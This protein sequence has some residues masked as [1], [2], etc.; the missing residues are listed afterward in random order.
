MS[1]LHVRRACD[2]VH[3]GLPTPPFRFRP[4][5]LSAM[6]GAHSSWSGYLLV[7]TGSG[8]IPI[9]AVEHRRLWLL[10]SV[11]TLSIIIAILHLLRCVLAPES[12]PNIMLAIIS[13]LH[14]SVLLAQHS[15]RT[16][17]ADAACIHECLAG[18]LAKCNIIVDFTPPAPA[19]MLCVY[20]DYLI[21]LC[22]L[23]CSRRASHLTRL[24]G[25]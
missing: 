10:V 25:T 18:P 20:F 3:G 16:T 5:V 6:P 21:L 19:S 14:S 2:T 13:A 4:V 24:Q 15:P 22:I 23:T 11:N 7:R 12:I 17:L 8:E 9:R 1:G